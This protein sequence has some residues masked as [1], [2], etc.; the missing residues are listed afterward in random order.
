MHVGTDISKIY[1]LSCKVGYAHCKGL[2]IWPILYVALQKLKYDIHT[3]LP[4]ESY[5]NFNCG[6]I[7]KAIWYEY[8][9]S[10]F[11]VYNFHNLMCYSNKCQLFCICEQ[12][13]GV[14]GAV[15]YVN[16]Y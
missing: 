10:V 6:M 3:K 12:L 2:A 14:K 7:P 13:A 5:T 1:I 8:H 15:W 11:A 4:L 9:T 16:C